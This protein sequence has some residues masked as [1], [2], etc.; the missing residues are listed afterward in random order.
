MNKSSFGLGLGSS[1]TVMTFFDSHPFVTKVLSTLVLA[2]VST[3]VSQL[4]QR[5]FKRDRKGEE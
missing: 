3:V 1:I 4:V 5:L 2:V